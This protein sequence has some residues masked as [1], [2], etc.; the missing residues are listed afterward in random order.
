[1]YYILICP[2]LEEYGLLNIS[3]YS[4]TLTSRLSP[5]YVKEFIISERLDN[6]PLKRM[7]ETDKRNVPFGTTSLSITIPKESFQSK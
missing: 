4:E 1:M 2:T 3:E 7:C 6:F 5:D